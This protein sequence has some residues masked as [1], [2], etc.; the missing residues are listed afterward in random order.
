VGEFVVLR[1]AGAVTSYKRSE[2]V[3]AG[4]A[5]ISVADVMDAVKV[6]VGR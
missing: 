3:D 6:V 1:D 2:E 5:R 4:L